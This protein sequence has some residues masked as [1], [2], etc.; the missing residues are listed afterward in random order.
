MLSQ[1]AMKLNGTVNLVIHGTQDM[2]TVRHIKQLLEDNDIS[3]K[4]SE[5]IVENEACF[6]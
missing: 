4:S 1:E 2:A 3:Y 6:K 5:N